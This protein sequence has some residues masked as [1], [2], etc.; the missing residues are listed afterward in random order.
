MTPDSGGAGEFRG[1]LGFQRILRATRT[2]ITASQCTDRHRVRTWGLLGGK[3]GG[4]GA[5]LIQLDGKSDWQ[6]VTEVF[7]KVSSSKY[8]NIT[9][10]PGDRVKLVVPGGGGYGKPSDR[11]KERI[12][13]D[14]REGFITEKA[15]SLDYGL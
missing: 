14:I 6:P 5:T 9:I 12:E 7:G 2:D 10:R 1:G 4:N 15:A 13:E 8:S 3:E 11:E